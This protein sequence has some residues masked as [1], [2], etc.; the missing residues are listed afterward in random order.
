MFAVV[1]MIIPPVSTPSSSIRAPH[2]AAKWLASAQTLMMPSSL[3]PITET[4]RE[5]PHQFAITSWWCCGLASNIRDNA[6]NVALRVT[7]IAEMVDIETGVG[8]SAVTMVRRGATMSTHRA[9]PSFHGKSYPSMMETPLMTAAR[10]PPIA[11]LA[12]PS[13]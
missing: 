4:P 10:S 9:I 11:Q 12:K 3:T 1:L 5:V 7:M 2:P 13:T 8:L 6:P